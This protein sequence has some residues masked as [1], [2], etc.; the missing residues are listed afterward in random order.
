MTKIDHLQKRIDAINV[1]LKNFQIYIDEAVSEDRYDDALTMYKS[2]LEIKN[3]EPGITYY[4]GQFVKIS[5]ITPIPVYTSVIFSHYDGLKKNQ[6]FYIVPITVLGFQDDTDRFLNN[7]FE[8]DEDFKELSQIFDRTIGNWYVTQGF[9]TT[10]KEEFDQSLST[11]YR[12]WPEAKKKIK[13]PKKPAS[14]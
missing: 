7:L 6:P 2:I 9:E 13:A 8:Y 11:Y 10:N 14:E 3:N 4:S 1:S 12:L 5:D